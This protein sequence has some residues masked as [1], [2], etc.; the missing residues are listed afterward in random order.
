MS[1][2]GSV[3]G[4]YEKFTNIS[5]ELKQTAK[6]LDL[7]ILLVSQTSRAQTKDRRGELEVADLRGSGALEEDAATVMLLYED[8]KDAADA[9]VEGDGSRYTK[10]PTLAYLKLGKNRYGEQGRSFQLIHTKYATRF[11][12]A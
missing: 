4:D 7:P 11:D 8:V 6:E 3:R 10:G 1:S 9:K 12:L 2:T 5:R